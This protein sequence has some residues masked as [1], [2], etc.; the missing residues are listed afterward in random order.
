MQASDAAPQQDEEGVWW[1][2]IIELHPAPEIERELL[3][4]A[5]DRRAGWPERERRRRA[6]GR[7]PLYP[8]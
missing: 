6:R 1:R 5:V 4:A 8:R 2:T 7:T 3:E